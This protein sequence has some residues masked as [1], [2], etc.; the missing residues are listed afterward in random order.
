MKLS[1]EEAE[2]FHGHLGP[3]LVIG[4]RIGEYAMEQLG[5]TPY[6]DLKVEVECP[7]KPPVRCL[8]DGLQLVTGATY[9]K[10]NILVK[11]QNKHVRAKITSTKNNRE[12]Q[13]ELHP[14]IP[15]KIERWYQ[16]MSEKKVVQNILAMDTRELFQIVKNQVEE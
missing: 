8:V 3:Y 2:K 1:L 6:F 5:I 12:I 7:P 9:G 10:A 11:E 16:E 14:D 15:R 4:M 13:I